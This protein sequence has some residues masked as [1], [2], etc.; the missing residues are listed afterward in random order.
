MASELKNQIILE[1]HISERRRRAGIFGHEGL[2]HAAWFS[3]RFSTSIGRPSGSSGAED[4]AG[5][6]TSGFVPVSVYGCSGL[7][8]VLRSGE[9]EGLDCNWES[10][11]KVLSTK[12]RDPY[13]ISIFYGIL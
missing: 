11:S 13:V 10:F 5:P 8:S 4:F 1:L 2:V 6:K 3:G 7:S 12:A 9:E